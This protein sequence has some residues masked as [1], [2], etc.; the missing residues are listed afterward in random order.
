MHTL[1]VL[2]VWVAVALRLLETIPA[3]LEQQTVVAVVVARDVAM[4]D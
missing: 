2:V 3:F 1:Q 4:V